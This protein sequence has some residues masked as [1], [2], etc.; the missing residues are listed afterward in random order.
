MLTVGWWAMTAL[1]AAG[2]GGRRVLVAQLRQFNDVRRDGDKE[3]STKQ[4]RIRFRY[5]FVDSRLSALN[6]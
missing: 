3:E 4:Y 2:A 1:F 6:F 5:C